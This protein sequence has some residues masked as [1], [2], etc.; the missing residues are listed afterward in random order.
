MKESNKI[1]II[2]IILENIIDLITE[3]V[4]NYN[5]EHN[6]EL[7]SE[8]IIDN[9]HEN[10]SELVNWNIIETTSRKKSELISQV[11]ID[12][13]SL[14]NNTEL[15]TNGIIDNI[16]TK[17][18]E[19]ITEEIVGNKTK[20]ETEKKLITSEIIFNCNPGFYLREGDYS[21]NK[22]KN[23]SVLGCE[24][25]HG[26]NTINYC[27]SC[28]FNYIPKYINNNLFCLPDSINN[29]FDYNITFECFKCDDEFL[30]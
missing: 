10:Y 29:C 25:C 22:C 18:S 21:E 19:I 8:K 4:S 16:T 23:C 14:I 30:L 3:I 11:F 12:N 27:D 5:D 17:L 2:E 7:I 26:N 20:I 1:N 13:I 28:S 24:I 9:I 15:I 6:S